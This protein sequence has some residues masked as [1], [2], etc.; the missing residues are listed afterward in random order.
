[1]LKDHTPTPLRGLGFTFN[2]RQLLKSLRLTM[3]KEQNCGS[4][5]STQK[6]KQVKKGK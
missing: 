1:M 2:L 4:E 3:A 6:A 5:M